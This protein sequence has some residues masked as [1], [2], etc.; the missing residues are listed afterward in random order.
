MRLIDLSMSIHPMWRWP[1]EIGLAMD[2]ERGDPYRVTSLK[3]GMH[4]FT[5]VDTPLHIEPGRETIDQVE[6]EKLC[7]P[8]AVIT[9]GPIAPNQA[10]GRGLLAERA[11]HIK[12]ND[13]LILKT[14]WD[15][16]RDY[17][18]REYWTEAPYLDRDAA[19][20]ISELPVKAVGFDF[21][22]DYVLREIPERHPPVRE[23]PTHDLILRRGIF[24]LEYLC[25]LDS[26]KAD[27]VDIY[28]LPLKVAGAEGACARVIA[29]EH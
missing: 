11:G 15:L 5:H 29:V 23:M 24:L 21:P 12:P 25:N 18:N 22:Q 20:W 13:I 9:L 28:A 1:A 27:R 16:V 2:F 10:I 26:V 7:G 4:F 8:A 17:E 3:A 19:A 6:L 14:C